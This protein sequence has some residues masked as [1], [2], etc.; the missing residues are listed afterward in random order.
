ME[1]TEVIIRKPMDDG[2]VK[3]YVSVTS[4][5][6]FAVHNIKVLNG[7][8]GFFIVMPA[9]RT[10]S[11]KYKSTAHPITPEFRTKL[12]EKILENIT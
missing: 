1:I 9:H 5:N 8:D 12:Q 3:A 10:P 11:G 7:Q 6:R 4:N 2:K